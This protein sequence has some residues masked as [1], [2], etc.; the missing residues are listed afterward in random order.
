MEE[1]WADVGSLWCGFG[2]CRV[3]LGDLG[4]VCLILGGS[5]VGL[6]GVLGGS[7]AVLQEFG[8]LGG[9]SGGR[10]RRARG[11]VARKGVGPFW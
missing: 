10:G 8:G 7:Q 3:L 5:W 4:W 6:G 1:F 11:G 9:G 2:G